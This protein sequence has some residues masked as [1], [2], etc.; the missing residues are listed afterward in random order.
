MVFVSA[1]LGGGTGLSSSAQEAASDIAYVEAVIGR[2]VAFAAHR[3]P[4]PFLVDTLDFITIEPDLINSE[5]R[6]ALLDFGF[7]GGRKPVDI[8]EET[9]T[10]E[11]SEFLSRPRIPLRLRDL[12]EPE[13][14]TMEDC[15]RTSSSLERRRRSAR[16]GT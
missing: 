8:S 12:I 3:A 2:V 10:A 14:F 4:A 15:R 5:Q 11:P 9:C 1:I 7:S 16:S 6:A 13:I